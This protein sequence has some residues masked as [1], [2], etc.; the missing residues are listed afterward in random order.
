MQ[1]HINTM[2]L[3]TENGVS[4]LTYPALSALPFIR[5]AFSTRLGGV[6]TGDFYSM[7]LSFGRG[8]PDENVLENSM[9][10]LMNW[11]LS[12]GVTGF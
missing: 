1:F 6:S 12:E 7:N 2:T 3:Q 8:D 5:H 10:R 4:F 11:H 9:R